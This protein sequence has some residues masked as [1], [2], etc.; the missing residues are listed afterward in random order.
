MSLSLQ[1]IGDAGY[2]LAAALF[3]ALAIFVLRGSVN[4]IERALL[5]A[6][7]F[8]TAAWALH[9]AVNSVSAPL[10]GLFESVRNGTWLLFMFALLRRGEGRLTR[11]PLSLS[12]I[13][14]VLGG[15]LLL[16]TS[17]DLAPAHLVADNFAALVRFSVMLRMMFAIGALVLVHNL[18]T[19]SA[20]EGRARIVMVMAALAA[21]WTYDLNLYSIA[22]ISADNVSELYALRG[23]GMAVLAVVMGLGLRG[24]GAWRLRLSRTVTFRSLSIAAVGL[25]CVAF[26][27]VVMGIESVAGPYAR[28]IE[29]ALLF[30]TLVGAI[31]MLPSQ[32]FR[33]LVKMQVAKH[34]FQHRYDY[35]AEWI[36]FVDTIG[37]PGEGAAPLHARVVKAMADITESTGGLLLLPDGGGGLALECRWNWADVPVPAIALDP[38]D[39]AA[40]ERSGAIMDLDAARAKGGVAGV[41]SWM[42]MDLNAWALVPLVHFDRL[43]GAILLSRPLVDRRLDWE[44]FDMLRAAGRQVASYLREAQG[45]QALDDARRFDEFNRRFAFIMHDLKNLVSQLSLLSHNAERHAENPA[46]RADMLLTLRESVG[47]MNDL[48]ARLSQHNNARAEEP[49]PT[50]VLSIARIVALSRARQ[51]RIDVRGEA[52][53]A[54]ADPQRVEQILIHLVQNAIDASAPDVP[55]TLCLGVRD[56]QACIDVIDQG[57]GM[58]AEF[59]RRDLFQP[60]ASSKPGGFG[61]GAFEARA[62]ALSMGG[63]LDVESSPGE[64]SRFTLRLPLADA[65]VAVPPANDEQERAA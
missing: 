44:D 24:G 55:V 3:A 8:L 52:P 9:T 54:L 15:L 13:Y 39:V 40:L 28:E 65:A 46:F 18:F 33:A 4:S 14:A 12:L 2:A 41:A 35:R 48:L 62:L 50:D 1:I 47:R 20:P 58:S 26:A 60:F 51:H 43:A 7:T 5:C 49:R 29:I 42:L 34:F 19:I 61:I 53:L 17:A 63:R 57:S 32:R 56:G 10:S 64:G 31:V 16:Q 21:M 11:H 27:L 23:A 59:I 6:G 30:T 45:Q 36:R 22:L 25:Y 37:A 38:T